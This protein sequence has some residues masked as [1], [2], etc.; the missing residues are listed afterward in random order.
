MNGWIPTRK[1]LAAQV[2]AVA[3]IATSAVESG[4][5]VTETKLC[6]AVGVQA[7]VT[8]LLPNSS[9]P[10]GVPDAT[11]PPAPAVVEGGSSHLR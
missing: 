3:G 10:G 11:K 5:D 6:I 9:A 8:Y 7:I 1:W 4:W 2:V